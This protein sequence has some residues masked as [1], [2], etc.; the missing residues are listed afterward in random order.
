MGTLDYLALGSCL[1]GL[2][3]RVSTT[4]VYIHYLPAQARQAAAMPPPR[5]RRS[6][7]AV[8]ATPVHPPHAV[9]DRWFMGPV[10]PPRRARPPRF[11][12]D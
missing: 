11:R 8:P 2:T 7:W 5:G 12:P 1:D 9:A 4:F 6:T 3:L 10:A